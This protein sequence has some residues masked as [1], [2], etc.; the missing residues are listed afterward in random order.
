MSLLLDSLR[1]VRLAPRPETSARS[2]HAD[3][4]LA[5]LGYGSV[6]RPRSSSTRVVV[7]LAALV[8]L[9]AGWWLWSALSPDRAGRETQRSAGFNSTGRA[10]RRPRPAAGTPAVARTSRTATVG[11]PHAARATAPDPVQASPPAAAPAALAPRADARAGSAATSRVSRSSLSDF[12]LALYYQRAGDFERALSHYRAVLERNEL[13]AEA[14]NNLGLLYQQKGLLDESAR[15][16]TRATLIN[17][18]YARAHNNLGVT[19]MRQDKLDLAAAEFELAS[20][21]DPRDVDPRVNLALVQKAAGSPETAMATLLN[22]LVLKPSSA[23]AHYNLALLY[24]ESGDAARAVEHYRD[25]LD[26][27]GVEHASLAPDV[28]ARIAALGKSQ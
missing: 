17:A 26:L 25:F 24:D 20:S 22:A 8:A 16:F 3:S 19:L 6:P 9:L 18:R 21:L 4:V 23:A 2:A 10:D 13:N 12:R 7:L 11:G 15:E 28:R 27:A 1:K 5:T 14:H